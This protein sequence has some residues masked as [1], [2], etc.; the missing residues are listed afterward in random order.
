MGYPKVA[1]DPCAQ[2][3]S[4]H[5]KRVS[6]DILRNSNMFEI[7]NADTGNPNDPEHKESSQKQA[8]GAKPEPRSKP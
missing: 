7:D 3:N 2:S 8:R 4:K 6:P 5:S 1:L